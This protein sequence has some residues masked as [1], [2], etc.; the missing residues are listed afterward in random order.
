M[1]RFTVQES[2]T[3]RAKPKRGGKQPKTSTTGKSFPQETKIKTTLKLLL[4]L[5][6]KGDLPPVPQ[7]EVK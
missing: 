7:K 6:R 3:K 5:K 1:K 2:Y 4:T